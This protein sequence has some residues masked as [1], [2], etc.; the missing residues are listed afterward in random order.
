MGHFPND[1]IFPKLS[2]PPRS[3]AWHSVSLTMWNS[4][5]LTSVGYGVRLPWLKP[6]LCPLQAA[7][8][9]VKHLGSVL[10][11]RRSTKRQ[12]LV[13]S[14]LFSSPGSWCTAHSCFSLL[15]K[16]SEIFQTQVIPF[17]EYHFSSFLTGKFQFFFKAHPAQIQPLCDTFS[18]LAQ[19]NSFLFC[20]F[21]DLELSILYLL[22]T[23]LPPAKVSST[24]PSTLVSHQNYLLSWC[25]KYRIVDTFF[26]S[27]PSSLSPPHGLTIVLPP[28]SLPTM[29]P[30]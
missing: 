1:K 22:T 13:L 2:A 24:V 19:G 7:I 10:C 26:H 4:P 8:M 14:S 21:T 27:F 20:A 3:L 30:G 11:I 29:P 25:T 16:H 17:L 9:L 18:H 28:I 6:W 15:P 23:F 12:L 5:V